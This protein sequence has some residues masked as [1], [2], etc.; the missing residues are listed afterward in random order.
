MKIW[1]WC[2]HSLRSLP[3]WWKH[4]ETLAYLAG[5]LGIQLS[6][7]SSSPSWFGRLPLSERSPLSVETWTTGPG[8]A[9]TQGVAW[10][11]WET[12]GAPEI[13]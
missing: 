13:Y 7:S 2:A 3:F 12:T 11:F 8:L 5:C 10:P 9:A 4:V 1:G 6:G